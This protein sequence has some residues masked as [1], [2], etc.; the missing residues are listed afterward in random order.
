M[1]GHVAGKNSLTL[2]QTLDTP[3]LF[4]WNK[5]FLQNFCLKTFESFVNFLSLFKCT[6]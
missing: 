5:K 4:T 6:F 2:I 3:W 1:I